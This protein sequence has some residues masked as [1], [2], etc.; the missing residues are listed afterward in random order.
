MN[1]ERLTYTIPE[2]AKLLGVNKIAAYKLAKRRDFP[3]ITIGKR[4]VVPRAALEE[5]LKKA[6]WQKEAEG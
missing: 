5:W 3:A 6:A 4:I 2:V 1:N